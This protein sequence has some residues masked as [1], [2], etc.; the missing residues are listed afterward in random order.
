MR[1]MTSSRVR[2]VET[3]MKRER[4]SKRTNT[5]LLLTAHVMATTIQV[6]GR[7]RCHSGV[8]VFTKRPQFHYRLTHIFL[9]T[10]SSCTV[11]QDLHRK[12]SP[13]PSNANPAPVL[14]LNPF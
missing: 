2:N 13:N 12:H 14:V 8:T 6:N 11:S 5:R 10:R 3:N 9:T 1:K 4:L 7:L